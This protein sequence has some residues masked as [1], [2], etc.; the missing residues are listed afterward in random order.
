MMWIAS[1]LVTSISSARTA[2]KGNEDWFSFTGESVEFGMANP[3]TKLFLN[4]LLGK[5]SLQTKNK[6]PDWFQPK[7]FT[8]HSVVGRKTWFDFLNGSMALKFA[9]VSIIYA[10][11]IFNCA[12]S[13][14]TKHIFGD[15][16]FETYSTC[17]SIFYFVNDLCCACNQQMDTSICLCQGTA[18]NFQ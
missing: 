15:R 1:N 5:K 4:K 18:L 10:I 11:R 2:D 16:N 12:L 13:R 3:D 6:Q 7:I 17:R 14:R 9:R 8:Q